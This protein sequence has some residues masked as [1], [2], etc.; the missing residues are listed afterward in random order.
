MR[1]LARLLV[2]AAIV[3]GAPAAWACSPSTSTNLTV[4]STNGPAIEDANCNSWTLVNGGGVGN[5][6][7][8]NGSVFASFSAQV[9]E[10]AFVSGQIWQKN[11]AN[12]WWFVTI[13]TDNWSPSAG[14]STAPNLATVTPSSNN[15]SV[16]IP[17]YSI[18]DASG[19]LWTLTTGGQ[20]A[21]NGVVDGT[22]S[23][24]V[25]LAYAGGLV[26]QE[27]A[28]G[29]WWSK[30]VPSD[31][32]SPPGGSSVSPLPVVGIRTFD[33]LQSLGVNTH[34]EFGGT[35][36]DNPSVVISA[37]QYMGIQYTRDNACNCVDAD[38]DTVA[39]AGIKFDMDTG[40][41]GV[42][43][44]TLLPQ[45]I[46][47]IIGAPMTNHPGSV[48]AMEGCNEVNS[49]VP[50]FYNGVN[51]NTNGS[52]AATSQALLW[53]DMQANATMQAQGVKV[54]ALSL[55]TASPFTTYAAQ[56]GNISANDDFG[57]WHE[58]T[59]AQQPRPF[60]VQA[61]SFAQ[62][63]SPGRP[64]W[65]TETGVCSDQN[66]TTVQMT[67][68][69]NTYLDNFQ[70]GFARTFVY[71]LMENPSD[72]A[73]EGFFGMVS[74]TGT[75]KPVATAIRNQFFILNDTAPNAATFSPA[76]F[77]YSIANLPATGFSMLMQKASGTY[78][79][80]VWGEAANWNPNTNTPITPTV[81]NVTINLP[82]TFNQANVYDP[83]ISSSIQAT[84][85]NV[86]SVNVA[87]SDHPVIVE[88]IAPNTSSTGHPIL[89]RS[90]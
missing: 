20:V 52:I 37:M 54:A 72:G 10:I 76:A 19:N 9:T 89:I 15:T 46:S 75:P 38:F 25:Q 84:T 36:Y 22:T 71:E 5:Q 68:I 83:T 70:L 86:T 31:T 24:V 77:S 60:M 41:N 56:V 51:M 7:W 42:E 59:S 29:I 61:L 66:N 48:F 6:V 73:C 63:L 40:A 58:Y 80:V 69:M 44:T 33:F 90:Q 65:I 45:Q 21:V 2:L 27:N 30:S 16:K 32:W 85:T 4:V 12:L 18:T 14:T 43:Y 49:N 62:Q 67:V 64:P 35:P 23:S 34:I 78:E 79:L 74:V 88:L 1:R 39:A 53:N 17:G 87:I 8:L 3:L 82:I 81:T 28:G 50:C 55:F 11:A 26:Y 57:N 47:G 13:T